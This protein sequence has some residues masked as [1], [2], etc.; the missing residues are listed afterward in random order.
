MSFVRDTCAWTSAALSRGSLYVEPSPFKSLSPRP[1]PRKRRIACTDRVRGSTNLW[2][3][4]ERRCAKA[5]A[6]VKA[7][8]EDRDRVSEGLKTLD[9]FYSFVSQSAGPFTRRC[10]HQISETEVTSRCV[11]ADL[12]PTLLNIRTQPYGSITGTIANGEDVTITDEKPDRTGNLWVYIVGHKPLGWSRKNMSCAN[13]RAH[14][15]PSRSWR[16]RTTPETVV[17]ISIQPRLP[18][19]STCPGSQVF[20]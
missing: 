7:A 11:I 9:F 13:H 17:P 6:D 18:A 2:A 8:C 15:S 1:A 20:V 19:L 14:L 16:D 12:T 10:G 4:A 5:E 3:N